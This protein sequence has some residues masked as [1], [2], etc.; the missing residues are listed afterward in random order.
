M[1]TPD[2]SSRLRAAVDAVATPRHETAFRVLDL[3][4]SHAHRA[5]R[6]ERSR[7]RAREL[8][9]TLAEIVAELDLTPGDHR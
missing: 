6:C 9:A 7:V 5:E 8:A 3:H 2:S 4:R 1:T